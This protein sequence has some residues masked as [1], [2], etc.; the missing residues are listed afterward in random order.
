MPFPYTTPDGR[1]IIDGR[2]WN[3]VGAAV[4]IAAVAGGADDWA[5]YIGAASA[6]SEWEAYGYV[7]RTGAKLDRALAEFLFPDAAARL[8]WRR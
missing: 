2:F 8:S 4:A 3:S 7:A 6:A 5:A 1:T